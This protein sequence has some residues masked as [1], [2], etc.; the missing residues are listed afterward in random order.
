MVR[1]EFD[2]AS[3]RLLVAA[4]GELVGLGRH[5]LVEEALDLRRR[6]RAAELGH[7]AAVVERLDGGDPLNSEEGLQA[8]VPVDVDL[9]QLDLA[10]SRRNRPLE[11]G[12]ELLAG[13]APVRP[14]VDDHR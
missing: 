11:N 13:P 2:R 8:L 12:S 7:D 1:I 10:L 9:G 14:E 4:R 6:Q 5:E 3:E